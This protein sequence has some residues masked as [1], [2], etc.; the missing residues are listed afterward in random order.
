[1]VITS[2]AFDP[3]GRYLATGG[4]DRVI[5]MWDIEARSEV[6]E[7]DGHSGNIHSLAFVGPGL[8]PAGGGVVSTRRPRPPPARQAPERPVGG[9]AALAAIHGGA[10][11]L[12]PTNRLASQ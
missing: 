6:T 10:W 1:M 2:A 8:P 11:F 7:L 4:D 5:K 9:R 12:S 3:T